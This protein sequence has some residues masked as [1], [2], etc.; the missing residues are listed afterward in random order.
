MPERIISADG[1]IDLPCIPTTL[2]T[3]YAPA[4]LRERV[5]HVVEQDGAQVWITGDGTYIG[6][7]GGVGPH[8][9]P[10]R[11][12]GHTS[13][14]LDR[15]AETG[16]FKDQANGIMRPT[17]PELRAK[18]MDRDGIAGEVIYGILLLANNVKDPEAGAVVMRAYNEFLADFCGKLPGRFAGVGVL[19]GTPEE[20]AAEVQRCAELGLKGAELALEIGMVPLWHEQWEPIWQAG[21][22]T[23]IPI[24]LHSIG[25]PLDQRWLDAGHRAFRCVAATKTTAFQ[26][27]MLEVL[28]E[29]M[30]SAALERHPDLRV[31]LGES[32]IGWLPYALE[33]MDTEWDQFKDLGLE[34]LPSEYWRRQMAASFQDDKTGID[35]IEA[36]GAETLMWGADFPHPDG[37]WPDSQEFIGRLFADVDEGTRRKV[38]HDNAA[39]LY[40]FPTLDGDPAT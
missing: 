19:A 5:P 14:R 26:I 3:D 17:V 8:G 36:I 9:A 24:H 18:D 39:R 25:A 35:N 16:L 28:S 23:R 10:R 15:M 30:W 37:T 7:V 27:G 12:G 13:P 1:H 4:H 22:E 2:F 20:A 38:L 6:H 34:L 32:G 33:R 40:D 21:A 31:V 29:I 11:P